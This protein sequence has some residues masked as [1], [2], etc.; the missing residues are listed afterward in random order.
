MRV[1]IDARMINASGIGRFIREILPRLIDKSP[2]L[3]F[4]LLGNAA[5]IQTALGTTARGPAA[6]ELIPFKAPIYSIREHLVGWW[7]IARLRP[8]LVFLPH[9]N[10]PVKLTAPYIVTIHD[11][12]HLRFPDIFGQ[13]RS[14]IAKRVMARAIRRALKVIT[15]STASRDDILQFFPWAETKIQCIP[16]GVAQIFRPAKQADVEAYRRAKRLP[17]RYFVTVGNRKPHKNLHIAV[18]AMKRVHRKNPEIGWVVVGPR[19]QSSDQV[20]AAKIRMGEALVELHNAADSDLR[21]IYAGSLGLL[22]P[23]RWEGFGLPALEAMACGIPVVA[24]NIP[25]LSELT[26]DSA[27]LHSPDDIDAFETSLE[28]LAQND[29]M[30]A[31]LGARGLRRAALFSWDSAAELLRSTILAALHDS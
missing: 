20:D 30:R 2:D 21:M 14:G 10:V 24:S 16:N 8:D 28:R 9:Y 25:A 7:M 27:L 29:D 18:E 26:A 6:H 3:D 1:A 15:V 31:D 5:E 13:L 17:R 19:F 22:M 11:V 4:S 23:S 12:T